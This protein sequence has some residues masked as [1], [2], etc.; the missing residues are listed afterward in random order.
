MARAAT[1]IVILTSTFSRSDVATAFNAVE[2]GAVAILEKPAGP[3]HPDH[4][5]SA[6]EVVQTVRL[7]AE[8]P[9]A[10]RWTAARAARRSP[11]R[12]V[13]PR[14]SD[15]V[16][17]IEIV[18]LGASTGGTVAIENILR[19]LPANAPG[20]VIAQHMPAI[21]TKNFAERLNTICAVDVREACDGDSVVA[22]VVLIKLFQRPQL[23]TAKRDHL[24]LSRED[25][26]RLRW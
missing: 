25:L 14:V 24:Q 11:S 7:M 9:V 20:T 5:R 8:V 26:Q 21:V 23:V 2:A 18:A 19:Y 6:R 17:N 1:P 3:A 4:A 15:R 16:S 10:R 22:G 12:P 13:E